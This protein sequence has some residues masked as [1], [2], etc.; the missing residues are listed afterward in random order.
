MDR[1]TEALLEDG[2]EIGGHSIMERLQLLAEDIQLGN[3]I[4]LTC[5]SVRPTVSGRV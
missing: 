4:L 1:R 2:G 5:P 3:D